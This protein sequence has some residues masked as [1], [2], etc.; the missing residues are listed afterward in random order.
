MHLVKETLK[1]IVT[2]LKINT[3]NWFSSVFVYSRPNGLLRT[4][5]NK[6]F[7]LS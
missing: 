3:E 7:G 4:M 6:T 5:K 1:E 2:F